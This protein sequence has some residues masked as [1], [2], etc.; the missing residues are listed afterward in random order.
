MFLRRRGGRYGVFG[1]VVVEDDAT[2]GVVDGCDITVRVS[3]VAFDCGDGVF[4]EQEVIAVSIVMMINT[5][6]GKNEIL[7]I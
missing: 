6:E 5:A 7:F 4:V 2:D 1:D 3:C